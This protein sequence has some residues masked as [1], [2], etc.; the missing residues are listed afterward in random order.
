MDQYRSM[1]GPG[2][3][4]GARLRTRD[5]WEGLTRSLQ[6][7][8]GRFFA[9]RTI[10]EVDSQIFAA[11]LRAQNLKASQFRNQVSFLRNKKLTESLTEFPQR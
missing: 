11:R 4:L 9:G 10:W 3:K 1:E 5:G 2:K 7:K 6:P 8:F